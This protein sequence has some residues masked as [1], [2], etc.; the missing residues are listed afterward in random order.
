MAN[1]TIYTGFWRDH[2]TGGVAADVLTLPLSSA[3][4][5]ISGLTL[6]VSPAGTM[7]W[8]ILVY[9]WHQSRIRP[10][11]TVDCLSLQLQVLLRNV[12]SPASAIPHAANIYLAWRKTQKSPLFRLLPIAIAASTVIVLFILASV[13]VT[14]IVS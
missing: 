6:L 2:S 1:L 5:L 11:T 13:F 14:T 3:G 4:Y 8:V 12:T 9:V 7:L 10:V